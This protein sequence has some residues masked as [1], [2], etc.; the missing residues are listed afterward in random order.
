MEIPLVQGILTG[1]ITA[2]YYPGQLLGIYTNRALVI[3]LLVGVVLDDTP[4]VSTFN[5]LV[6]LVCT[7][8][9]V[10]AGETVP[11][12]LVGP[13][14]V[15]TIMAIT[16]KH[17]RVIPESALTLSFLFT[18]LFQLVTTTIYTILSGSVKWSR[19]AIE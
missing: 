10:G 9:G 15:G 3:S 13:G 18:V 11:P 7:G 5:T 6:E 16:P 12:N 14:T 2:F 8:S 4:T 19:N 1:L 17:Q